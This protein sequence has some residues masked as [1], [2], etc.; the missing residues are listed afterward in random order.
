ME[1]LGRL[2]AQ[3]CDQTKPHM[4]MEQPWPTQHAKPSLLAME[5][6]AVRP[7]T[8]ICHISK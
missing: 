2:I 1:W 5:E 8:A 6:E 7:L 3:S 4:L